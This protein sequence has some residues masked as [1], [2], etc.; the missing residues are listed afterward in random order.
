MNLKVHLSG[1][2][3]VYGESVKGS[4]SLFSKPNKE[5]PNGSLYNRQ[6]RSIRD[7]TEFLRRHQTKDSRAMIFC[8]TS[9]GFTSLAN[10]PKFISYFCENMKANYGMKDYVWVREF[11]KRGFPHF[12]FIAHWN[13]PKWFFEERRIEKISLYW[14]RLFD[15]DAKNSVRLG[16]FHPVTKKRCFYVTHPKQ[17]HY[18]AKYIGKNIGESFDYLGEAGFPSVK[19]RKSIRSFGM[20]QNVAEF[21][22][23]MLFKDHYEPHG[24]MEAH[25]LTV[26]RENWRVTET[27]EEVPA[28]YTRIWKSDNVAGD[29]TDRDLAKYDWKRIGDHEVYFGDLRFQHRK[30]SEQ[31]Q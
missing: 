1:V 3:I 13:N 8:L 20:S 28:G 26:D 10:T 29:W 23:P 12:H 7:A 31:G 25:R 17:C 2:A 9:P 19:Y 18:L 30:T 5:R 11:T 6:K 16:S 22:Q 24:K 14:S 4:P 15:S 21:S 27:L